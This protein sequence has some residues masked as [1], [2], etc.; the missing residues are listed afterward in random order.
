MRKWIVVL[1]LLVACSGGGFSDSDKDDFVAGCTEG[2][3]DA[4]VCECAWEKITEEWDSSS[5]AEDDPE[6][7]AKITDFTTECVQEAG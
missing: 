3:A 2:G 4:A 7:T 6:F 5:E 1:T